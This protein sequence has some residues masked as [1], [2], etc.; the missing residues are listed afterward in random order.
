MEMNRKIFIISITCLIIDQISKVIIDSALKIGTEVH[1]IKGFFNLTRIG[2]TGA[3]FSI[4]EGRTIIL[5]ILSI[6]TIFML[7][8]YMKSFKETKLGNLSFG[9]VVGGILG[10]FI[11]RLFL[12]Y[13]RDFLSFN[14]FGYGFPVFNIADVCIVVGV[15]LLIVCMFRGDDTSE[16]SSKRNG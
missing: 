4:L 16:V 8:W 15:I 6:A 11:D 12:G 1:V 10:N 13:V 14:I 9:L 5:A 3:A 7:L 2:N